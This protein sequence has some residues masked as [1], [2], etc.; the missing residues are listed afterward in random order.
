MTPY[1]TEPDIDKHAQNWYKIRGLSM[2]V[3]Q[4]SEDRRLAGER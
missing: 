3:R 4:P 1:P 2:G